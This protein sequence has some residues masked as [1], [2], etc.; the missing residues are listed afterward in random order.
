M[1]RLLTVVSV[2]AL[3]L[4][5]CAWPQAS[6]GTV[7]G[8]VRDKSNA[9]IPNAEVVMRNTA[10]NVAS[11]TRCNDA[12]L[13][14]FP[15][16]IA[17]SYKL[18]VEVPGMQKFEGTFMVQATQSV[19]I[20]PVLSLGQTT[21]T[22]EVR[23]VTP[24]V[25]VDS[26]SMSTTM[27]R[28]RI[29]QL[30]I[31]GR[32]VTT[33]L[34]TLP[35]FEGSRT[36]GS[37]T[38]AQEY[39]LDGSVETDRRW[40]NPPG[41]TGPPAIPPGVDSV[42]EFAVQNN[43]VSAKFSRPVS[44]VL[45]TRS[46]TNGLHGSVFE[47]HRN[48]AIGLARSRTD[49][50]STPPRLIRNE[51]GGSAGGPLIIP[52][53]YNGKD[54][55]FWFV[56]AE[57]F[58]MAQGFT[59]SYNVP[60]AA[61]RNGD[62]SELKDS[63]GRLLT[64][65]D[66]WSTDTKTWARQPFNYGGKLNAI[67]PSRI[68]SVAK[69]LFSVTPAPTNNVN[70]L[71][72]YNW[73][74]QNKRFFH[75]WTF[76]SRFDHRFSERD[77]M[78]VRMNW[79]EIAQ[80]VDLGYAGITGQ[81][82]L[83]NVAGWEN[84]TNSV[85][86]LAVSWVH[87]FSPT[88]F[89][90]LLVTGHRDNWWGGSG[91]TDTDWPAKFGLSSPFGSKLWPQFEGI[92]LGNYTLITNDT[93]RNY[94]NY[95]IVE[96]NATKIYGKHELLFG[97]HYRR[98][99]LN[100][101]PQQR[102]PQP[103]VNYGTQATALY[104]TKSTPTNPLA[105][106]QTG[107]GI[108]NM[109]LGVGRY[110]N[111]LVHGFYYLREGEF[112]P[113]FQDN[114]KITPRLTLNLGLRWEYWP[115]YHEK[116]GAAVGFDRASHTVLLGTDLNTLYNLGATVP[117]M[118]SQYQSYGMKFGTYKDAGLPRDLMYSRKGNFGPRVGFAYRALE[119]K[120]SF[121]VRGGYSRAYFHL[122]L[123]SWMDT[124][125]YVTPFRGDF[126]YNPDDATQTPDGLGNYSMRSVPAFVDGVNTRNVINLSQPRGITRGSS[127]TSYIDP[128]LPTA[129]TQTWNL[130]FEKEVMANTVARAR[131]V[132]TR[133]TGLGQWYNYNN[134]PNDYLW[135]T[136]TGQ[137]KPTG[138]YSNVARRFYDQQVLGTVQMFRGTGRSNYHGLELEMERRFNKGY[139][140]QI[141]YVMGNSL[142]ATDGMP[143]VNQFLPGAVPSDYDQRNAFLNYRRDTGIPKHRI[144]WNWLMDLPFGKNK[145]IGRNAGAVV[146]KI[147]GGW[148]I[149]GLGNLRSNYYQL[150][151]GN[152]NFTG[153]KVQMYG[154][155]Y[156]IQ[157]CRSGTCIPGYLWWNGY[158][159][160][161]KINSVDSNGKPNGYMG[162]PSNYKPAVT[163]L[164]PW[165]TTTMPANA[166]AGTNISQYWDTNN[167]WIPLKDNTVQRV[168]YDNGM[169][170]WRNQYISGVRQWGL[171]A[172]LFKNFPITERF[173]LRFNADFFNVLNH[174]GNPN[175]IGGD[176]FLNTRSSGQDPRMLQL[177]L[178][179]RW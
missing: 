6:T 165:G 41:I 70:P 118:V 61:M 120:S 98:D 39:I 107:A 69:Y 167:V 100:I 144:R 142:V 82:M 129:A 170:P 128:N 53:L 161:N 94:Q 154:Y 110:T 21:T 152:W 157:D 95:V 9:V 150:P 119:G 29:E 2:I 54:K 28:E 139:A 136:T 130:T 172:S 30:P 159:P 17:G 75:N 14:F 117:A 77:Q 81:Q 86:S 27:E 156:P 102:F 38:G 149:A 18:S 33:L 122:S 4:V 126:N 20:D 73:W 131:Y 92:G 7:S 37:P 34:G 46:G 22:V 35:G 124:I 162:I 3:L 147:I 50:Y 174:P 49:F 47:T 66:P 179:L 141:S 78:Y 99:Q 83:N 59:A 85:K 112:A 138:E 171:D 116:N 43:A 133:G 65:Y 125:N 56:N 113:Y 25:T 151:A 158:I 8:T 134:N 55:T 1:F 91:G 132:G 115:A 106:P 137:P 58:R 176:G 145:L 12:G 168:G 93:K 32:S 163:P 87:T 60:T 105:L 104:D 74:G 57:A 160:S 114:F 90:D 97:V 88:L 13:Y 44:I 23:D 16:V 40:A 166:P 127:N 173:T 72:D 10:T 79:A 5:P 148:Q 146:D 101:L 155:Q 36:F 177:S 48:N 45:S 31:N 123:S 164:I 121:V 153:E 63:Q 103:T 51:F 11:T 111:N 108:A 68:S 175:S 64:L 42:Q 89:S 62:F 15:G 24:M 140:F 178:R 135:Y 84:N 76:S 80:N 143:E 67:D 52:K 96:E 26:P 109:F 19:V 71:I 169:N